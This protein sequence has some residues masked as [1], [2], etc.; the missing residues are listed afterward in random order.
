[1]AVSA[2][3]DLEAWAVAVEHSPLAPTQHDPE[4]AAA[5]ARGRE[6]RE[7]LLSAEGGVVSS[8][9]LGKLLGVT[10]QAIDKRR[11]NGSLFAVRER[12]DW[13]YPHWQL[14]NGEVLDGL[15]DVLDVLARSDLSAWDI[16]IFFLRTDTERE[17]ES[18]LEALRAGR[19]EAAL[20]AARMYG[21]HGAR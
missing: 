21:E 2:E 8:E 10:R 13:L 5:Y 20:R 16:M 12:G 6:A 3:S 19:R 14:A 1:M 4:L 9:E 18:P 15:A 11:R 17:G 7:A